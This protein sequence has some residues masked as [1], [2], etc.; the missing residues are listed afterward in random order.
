MPAFRKDSYNTRMTPT[1]APSGSS[2]QFPL[3]TR[4]VA[5][6]EDDAGIR[7]ELVALL[8]A[9]L[10]YRCV[11]ACDSAEKALIDI[12]F[13]R[14]DV[15]LMDINLPGI[16]G[17]ECVTRLKTEMPNLLVLMLTV[18]DDGESIFQALKAGANGYLVKRMVGISLL[19]AIEDVSTGGAPMSCQI[20]RKV[21][22]FFHNAG[23]SD[24]VS[25]NLSPR[26]VGV[27]ELLVAGYLLKEIADHM[28]IGVETVR[29]HVNHIYRKLHVRS[30]TE[31]V[32]KYLKKPGC[33]ENR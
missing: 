23:P 14:P 20:A 12:P 1:S 18:Y 3:V 19:D 6:V 21:V 33:R 28:S 32:V 7:V 9:T 30:R 31:A 2:I 16:S 5:V 11:G 24:E 27:L 26:E 22:Q 13:W 8:D 10:G 29:T 25:E 4:R 15:V 17:I